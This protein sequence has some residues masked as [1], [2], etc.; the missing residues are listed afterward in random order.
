MGGTLKC[1]S[2]GP[3]QYHHWLCSNCYKNDKKRFIMLRLRKRTVFLGVHLP[4]EDTVKEPVKQKPN[5]KAGSSF[6]W[7]HFEATRFV[8]NWPFNKLT[9]VFH[10]SVMNFVMTSSK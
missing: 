2:Q 4:Q 3:G 10:A 5:F 7:R 8:Y 1:L 6:K 9:P